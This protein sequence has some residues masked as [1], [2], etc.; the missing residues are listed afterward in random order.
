M[1]IAVI[2]AGASGLACAVSAASKAAEQGIKADIVLFEAA[3][4]VGKKILV[5]GNGRCNMM[6]RHDAVEN[7][8]CPDFVLPVFSR[9]T[10]EDNLR[11][12]AGLGL[13]TRTDSEGRI[14]PMSNQA[15]SVLDA[16]RFECERLGVQTRCGAA[17]KK[18]SPSGGGFLVESQKFDRVVI[19]CGGKAGVKNFCGYELL[20]DLGHRIV[21]PLPSL[22]K[23]AV[24][25]SAFTGSLQGIRQKVS[26]K[27]LSGGRLICCEQGELLFTKY[28]L[29]GIAVMQLSARLTRSL[30][31]DKAEILCDFV[32]DMDYDR[33]SMAVDRLIAHD[34]ER[35]C[36]NLLLGFMAKKLGAALVKNCDIS[37]AR[38]IGSLSEAEKKR[39]LS[40]CKKFRF[41]VTAVRGFEE[42]Q[43]T[44][45]GADIR[46]FDSRSLMSKKIPGLYCC[47]E[48]LDVDG[49]CG[50]YNLWWAFSS[51]RCVGES[52][53]D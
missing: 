43:V 9:Y 24:E 30:E 37:P 42:A 15:S 41:S 5:T 48:I 25:Q 7:F 35:K 39:I 29:S 6:N 33:L 49:L 47:G 19:A 46:E 14:Y 21:K 28:G 40:A 10:V 26:M 8:S 45:G 44:S 23:L 27:L 20:K 3:D 50:G 13:Y 2:G 32:P 4:R 18:I 12:F 11:F 51:G 1:K 52:L 22:T 31:K 34:P 53:M 36:E 38:N 17:V 16:L